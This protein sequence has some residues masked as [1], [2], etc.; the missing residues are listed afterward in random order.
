M[1]IFHNSTSLSLKL[2]FV[3]NAPKKAAEA[4]KKPS[5]VIFSKCSFSFQQLKSSTLNLVLGGTIKYTNK[6]VEAQTQM[7]R[8]SL[9]QLWQWESRTFVDSVEGFF[10]QF[11]ENWLLQDKSQP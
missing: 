5:N 2:Q 3:S 6:Q 4:Q 11:K 1:Y 10:G 9:S 8:I 7:Q